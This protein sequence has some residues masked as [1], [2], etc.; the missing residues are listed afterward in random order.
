MQDIGSLRIEE[1]GGAARPGIS[2][3]RSTPQLMP[4]RSLGPGLLPLARL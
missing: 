2:S 1:E 3:V 4:V